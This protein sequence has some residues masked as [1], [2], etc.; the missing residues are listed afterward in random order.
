MSP[1]KEIIF[2]VNFH[3]NE[4]VAI[5]VAKRVCKKLEEY[6]L[7]VN[8]IDLEKVRGRSWESWAEEMDR[9]PMRRHKYRHQVL[10][11]HPEAIVFDFHDSDQKLVDEIN[12][13]YGRHIRLPDIII[14][15][16][17]H[18]VE[19]PAVYVPQKDPTICTFARGYK[20]KMAGYFEQVSDVEKSD[21]CGLIGKATIDTLAE[22]I[23]NLCGV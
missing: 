10:T 3:P 20:G 4:L 2:T 16:K 8:I 13:Q 11:R 1:T 21:V 7:T 23:R 19:V 5:E 17:C 14:G 9:D 12:E 15:Q 18:E 22:K 6:G